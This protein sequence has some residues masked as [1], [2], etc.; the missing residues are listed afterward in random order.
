MN[1]VQNK[2]T[3]HGNE[4]S[5]KL[6]IFE[7]VR[8]DVGGRIYLETVVIFTSIFKQAVHGVQN[9]MRQE[10]EPLPGEEDNTNEKRTILCS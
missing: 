2:M 6:E 1:S 4:A 10:E 5:Y 7:V 3:N 8:I 9:L